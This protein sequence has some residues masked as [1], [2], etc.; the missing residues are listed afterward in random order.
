VIAF[1]EE[2]GTQTLLLATAD[3]IQQWRYQLPARRLM[4]RDSFPHPREE[5]LALL[6]HS[7]RDAPTLL[8][9]LHEGPS[10]SLQ[11][12][13]GG[14]TAPF[15]L[16]WE[17][18]A[19]VPEVTQA[20]GFLLVCGHPG[21]AGTLDC[22][23]A[24]GRTGKVLVQLSLAQRDAARVLLDDGHILLFDHAGRLVDICCEDSQVHALTLA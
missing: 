7:S 20:A 9:L 18:S 22:L 10:V 11:V 4:Q 19:A 15:A 13:Q 6:P 24:D 17:V 21:A 16:A 12:H 1:L 23:V 2:C 14:T 3:D 5:V 8:R